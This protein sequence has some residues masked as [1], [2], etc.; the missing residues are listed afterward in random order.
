VVCPLVL[1]EGHRHDQ[2][3]CVCGSG[4]GSTIFMHQSGSG[5][6]SGQNRVPLQRSPVMVI[7]QKREHKHY[8]HLGMGRSDADSINSDIHTFN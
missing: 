4:V 1:A 2:A 7:T 3:W 8:R 6:L 5:W